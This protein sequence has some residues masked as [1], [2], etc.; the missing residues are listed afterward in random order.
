[1]NL[2]SLRRVTI[3]NRV[4]DMK[5]II[6]IIIAAALILSLAACTVEIKPNNITVTTLPSFEPTEAA[7][8]TETPADVTLPTT[9]PSTEPTTG[10]FVPDTPDRAGSGD[11]LF[12]I[13]KG[14]ALADLDGNGTDEEIEFEAGADKSSLY[15]NGAASTI[16]VSGLAQLFAVTDVDKGDKYLELVFTGKYDSKLAD[17]E[18]AYSHVYWWDGSKLNPMGS[19]MDVKFAGAWRGDFDAAKHFKANGEV[20]CLAHTTELTDIWYMEELK[21]DGAGRKFTE[22]LDAF[23]PV[24]TP[25]PLTIKAGK[26]CLLLAHGDSSFFSNSNMWDYAKYPHNA[27]RVINP[28]ANIVIIAQGGETLKVV[29]V[30]GPNWVKLQTSDGYKGWI[31][32]VKGKVQGYNL[33]PADIFDGI[34]AAG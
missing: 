9:G 31:K 8:P 17:T 16:S 12:D 19:L 3:S 23:K 34:V 15:I 28:N 33:A 21:P 13:Y 1:M 24:N 22:I 18:F 4:I 27:G 14:K 2:A 29:A 32:V 7:G 20:Y 10:G 6:I 11:V 5:R 30:L 26:K 25:D